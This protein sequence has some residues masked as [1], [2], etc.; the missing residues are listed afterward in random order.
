[1]EIQIAFN[2]LSYYYNDT[3]IAKFASANYKHQSI[4]YNK[5]VTIIQMG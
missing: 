3:H 2:K 1:M 4:L 5:P